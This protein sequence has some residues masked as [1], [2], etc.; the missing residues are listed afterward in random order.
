MKDKF[1]TIRLTQEFY[2]LLKKQAEKESRSVSS[3][4]VHCLKTQMELKND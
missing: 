1:V 4:I 3:Q 2:L